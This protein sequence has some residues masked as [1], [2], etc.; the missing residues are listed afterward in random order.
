MS[1]NSYLA[2]PADTPLSVDQS[3]PRAFWFFFW[4]EFAERASYYGMRAIL[5]LY[6]TKVLLLSDPAA[7]A[8]FYWFKMGCYLLPLLGGFLA[9]RFFGKYWTIVGFSIPYVAGHF[10]LGIPQLLPVSLAL[11]LLA[12]GSGVIKP[13]I[14]T[15]MG[16]TYDRQRP[17]QERL[18]S[19]AFMWF[20]FSINVG[21]FISIL[22]LPWLRDRYGYAIAFQFPAWLMVAALAVFA[23]GKP[24]YVDEMPAPEPESPDQRHEKWAVLGRLFGVFGLMI[25]FWVAYEHNDS[26]WVFF[27]RDHVNLE[28]S[29]WNYVYTVPPDQIQVINPLCVLLMVPIFNLIFKSLDPQVRYFTAM[30]KIL[31]GF[32]LAVAAA[33]V[34]SAAG[35]LAVGTGAK[36]SIAFPVVAYIFLTAGEVLL[37]GTGLELAYAV[38]PKNMKGFVTACFLLTMTLGNFINVGLSQLYGPL[39]PGTFFALSGGIALAGALAFPLVGR[40]LDRQMASDAAR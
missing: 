17:G 30:R 29:I 22:C 20:Y 31:G 26:L 9:D 12:C 24:Y 32:I 34:M 15:L 2:P 8:L 1:D 14:S 27:A 18:R 11:V 7:G 5:P 39:S 4:G 10:I 36:V 6:L 3:H 19:A 25:F 23:L 38:A 13:N 16:Q 37:Y 28:V 21:S 40:Q 33:G 35:Y